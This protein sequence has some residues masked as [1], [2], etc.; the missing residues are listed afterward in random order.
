MAIIEQS[1]LD[2]SVKADA[3]AVFR[4]LAHAEARVHRTA[5]ES[6]HFHEVGAM[7]AIIDVVGAVAGLRALGIEKI[8]CSPL[9]L[10]SG[11]VQCAHGTLPVPAPATAE[12]VKGKPVY[13][14]GV[15]GELLTPTGA[16]V[17]TTLAKDFGPMP[18]L[19][20]EAVGYGA[21]NAERS[22]PNLLRVV[23]GKMEA[24]L[25][26]FETEQVVVMETN[27][28]DMNPQIYDHII[29]QALALGALDIYLTPVHMKK[30]R[31][32]SVLTIICPPP[33]AG[34]FAQFLLQETTTIGLR[35][36]IDQRLKAR[37]RIETIETPFGPMPV[38][39]AE[40][41]GKVVNIAPEYEDCRRVALEKGLPLKQ[42]MDTVRMQALEHLG[43]EKTAE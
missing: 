28:D 2:P 37:R 34:R 43:R 15:Q 6:V 20:V 5:V 42:V 41:E 14:T 8:V 25:K 3:I 40:I 13:S 19:T 30:N 31:S 36:R 39:V 16:A 12:L 26:G 21:G 32:G 35:W 4:R 38:K 9:H 7:D 18:A 11:T 17:L 23:I 22:I 27:I 1:D 29:Q 33:M 10:G 24:E